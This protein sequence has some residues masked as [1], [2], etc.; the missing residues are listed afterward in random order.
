MQKISKYDYKK[1][2]SKAFYK[3]LNMRATCNI[4]CPTEGGVWPV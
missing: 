2:N 4:T 3:L 1:I